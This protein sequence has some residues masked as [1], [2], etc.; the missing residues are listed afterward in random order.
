MKNRLFLIAR[1]LIIGGLI[2]FAASKFD[3]NA[4][5]GVLASA[6]LGLGA[7]ALIISAVGA[8]F[9]A[10]RLERI[11]RGFWPGRRFS[12]WQLFYF[13]YLALFYTLFIPTSIAGETVRAI[14]LAG[15]VDKD[16]SRCIVAVLLD[17]LL[18]ASTWFLIFLV[19]PSPFGNGKFWIAIPLAAAAVFFLRTKITLFGHEIFDISRHHKAD[20]TWA[21]IHSIAGQLISVVS[22]YAAF[23][24]FGIDLSLPQVAGLTALTTLAGIVPLSLLGVGMREGSLLGLLPLYGVSS[25]QSVFVITFWFFELPVRPPGRGHRYGASRVEV[26]EDQDRTGKSWSVRVLWN[27]MRSP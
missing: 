6:S 11:I 14:K 23:L 7:A 22:F 17:R 25:T 16:R 27:K 13:N 12:V 8:L 26:L 4:A 3:G 24:C 9:N 19:C 1:I 21:V 20:M 10:L 5:A 15:T 2:A 18:G